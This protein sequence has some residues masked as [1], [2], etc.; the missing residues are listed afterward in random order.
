MIPSKYQEEFT[1][2]SYFTGSNFCLRPNSFFDIAQELAV[3]GSTQLGVPDTMLHKKGIGW[4]LIR[5]ALQFEKY[6]RIGEKT[7]LQ[8]WHFGVKGPLYFRNY[9]MLDADGQTL[10]L[11]TSSWVLMDIQNRSVVKP[12][13]IFDIISAEPQCDEVT[14]PFDPPKLVMPQDCASESAGV[15]TVTYTDVDYNRHANNAKYPAWAMDCLPYEQV[16]G[17]SVKEFQIN[18]NHEVRLGDSVQLYRAQAT[19]GAWYVEGRGPDGLP[20]F[21]CR[22]SFIRA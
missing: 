13:R 16:A 21:I 17:G 8:S 10:V 7:L 4:I 18:Y 20:S 14:L 3:R 19:D 15:H 2:P 12:S 11:G 6:P 1:I 5:T 22:I 9:R